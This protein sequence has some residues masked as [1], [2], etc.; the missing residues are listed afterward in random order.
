MSSGGSGVASAGLAGFAASAA[1]S[2]TRRSTSVMSSS[3]RSNRAGESLTFVD[4][5]VAELEPSAAV[6]FDG[7]EVVVQFAEQQHPAVGVEAEA[8]VVLIEEF[9]LDARAAKRLTTT[10]SAW[11]R[12]TSIR[13]KTSDGLL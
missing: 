6:M 8:A 12:N 5:R 1:R 9:R 10:R 2:K 4:D 3:P 11:T 13:S 7:I